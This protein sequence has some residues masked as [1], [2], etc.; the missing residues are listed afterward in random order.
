MLRVAVRQITRHEDGSVGAQ[1]IDNPMCLSGPTVI[2]TL[3]EE[4]R[5]RLDRRY[6]R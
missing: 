3:L 1:P 2:D 4:E 5:M 6:R